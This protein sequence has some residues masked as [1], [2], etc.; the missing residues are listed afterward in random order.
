VWSGFAQI[1]NRRTPLHR[2]TGGAPSD[3]DFLLSG[4]T[5]TKCLL[6]VRELGLGLSYTPGTGILIAGKVLRHGVDTWEGGERICHAKFIKDSVHDRLGQQRPSWVLH[7]DY[8]R[9]D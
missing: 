1:V 8:F 4:G 5:H 6:E 3:Y 2:D 7:E 9:L